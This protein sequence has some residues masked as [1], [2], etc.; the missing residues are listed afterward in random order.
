MNDITVSLSY[1]SE[2]TPYTV[3]SS[4]RIDAFLQQLFARGEHIPNPSSALVSLME[5]KGE[6]VLDIGRSFEENDVPDN[7]VLFLGQ[8]VI[9]G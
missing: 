5:G 8:K 9:G 3:D 7:A 2:K 4:M 6:R 1:N